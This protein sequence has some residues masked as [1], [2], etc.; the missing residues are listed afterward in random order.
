MTDSIRHKG[1]SP[2]GASGRCTS[3]SRGHKCRCRS[4][5]RRAGRSGS[6]T[7]RALGAVLPRAAGRTHLRTR[8]RRRWRRE[9][10][11]RRR[12]LRRRRARNRHRIHER[13]GERK[14]TDLRRRP[15]HLTTR[16]NRPDRQPLT[17]QQATTIQLL[18]RP[19]HQPRLERQP[20]LR[21]DLPHD[22]LAPAPPIAR[23][24]H[25]RRDPREA[26]RAMTQPVINQQLPIDPLSQDV[27]GPSQRS[28]VHESEPIAAAPADASQSFETLQKSPPTAP[29]TSPTAT[30][31]PR[32]N[33]VLAWLELSACGRP[34]MSSQPLRHG[35]SGAEQDAVDDLPDTRANPSGGRLPLRR[36]EPE[37]PG[38]SR[39][40]FVAGPDC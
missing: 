34:R 19:L 16:K 6:C 17:Y 40:R 37:A 7:P 28:I 25:R 35:P 24:P 31:H 2:Q 12:R 15:R 22:L 1:G 9:R 13:R 39:G 3:R 38:A 23:L 11:R 21:G 4:S 26:M 10:W 36:L 14:T 5:R 33:N 29:R 27:L 20:Q 30:E 32:P 8:A 18:Q